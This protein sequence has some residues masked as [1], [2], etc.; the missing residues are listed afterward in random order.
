V[1]AVSLVAITGAQ[2]LDCGSIITPFLGQN[3]NLA[4][5]AGGALAAGAALQS[6]IVAADT[7]FLSQ[8]TAFVS[9]PANPQP[10]QEG[11][12][13]WARGVGGNLNFKSNTTVNTSGFPAGFSGSTTCNT[14]FRQ[15]FG[16]FQVGAD[17][18]AL[19]VG[20][21]NLHAGTT[22][23]AL[24]SRGSIVGGSP[25][26]G[27]QTNVN[28]M[29]VPFDATTRSPFAGIYVVVTNGGFFADALIRYNSYDMS[30]NSPAGS[31]FNQK[32]D[33]HGYAVSGSMGYN[34]QLPNSRWFIEPSAGV[35]WS[36]TSV[37]PLNVETPFFGVTT[38][39]F[40]MTVNI[41]DV[42]SVIGRLGLRVGTTVATDTI[43]FQPFVTASVWH[44]FSGNITSTAA[45]CS[46]CVGNGNDFFTSMSTTNIGTFGQYSVGV[47][48][49]LVNTGWLGYVRVDYRDGPKM[50]S[51]SG[52]GGIRYQFTPEG[53][54]RTAMPVKALPYK[55][56]PAVPVSWTGW[57]VGGFG[58][59]AYG[60]SELTVPPAFASAG[61]FPA[62]V[63]AGGTLGYNYQIDRYVL[64][65]EGEGAWTNTTGSASCA[66][67]INNSQQPFFQT[68][69]HSDVDWIATVAGRAGYLLTPR[70]LLYVKGGIAWAGESWSATC[71]LGSLNGGNNPP[72]TP[73]VVTPF[74]QNCYN[75]TLAFLNSTSVSET[76]LGGLV[77]FGTE[78]ALHRDWSVKGE[79]D[80]IGFGN[81]T[82]TAPDG[83]VFNTKQSI[84]ET[85]VGVNYH[86]ASF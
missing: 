48:G 23:G 12:G 43:N 33:A 77:G 67:L 40:P 25:V 27:G 6:S 84:F 58:G 63:L 82:L 22:A 57:Y 71:N 86:F 8:S 70:T 72:G 3:V 66:P 37:E 51:L 1:L 62:G 83:T 80:W 53:A 21:W 18:A 41:S 30:L 17:V 15:T 61:M 52:N 59:A 45:T 10:N 29:Q 20:G 42:D 32:A 50:N 75:S 79:F 16:G 38:R 4:G 55:A 7:A 31:I 74:V 64:G 34:Y 46:G 9:A 2:A 68:T 13:V 56:P 5:L 81:R 54:V 11:G 28:T 73:G 39:L 65:V 44:D 85:K 14:E 24:E 78:F 19:N 60:R 69:C 35:I 49:Q 26:G 47:S 76:R 36:R